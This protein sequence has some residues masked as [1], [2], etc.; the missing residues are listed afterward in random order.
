M[1]PA[2][3]VEVLDALRNSA[4]Y[5]E[6]QNSYILYPNKQLPGFLEKNNVP[7][8]SVR[9]SRLLQKMIDDENSQ[10][11]VKDVDGGY[12]FNGSFRNVN[13]L[14]AGL[15]A[16]DATE[17]AS[18]AQ[19]EEKLIA[20]IFEEV[21]NHKAFTGRSGTFFAYEG[22]GSI[23]WHMV[24]KLHLAVYEICETAYR[25]D[26]DLQVRDAL[27]R[28]FDEIGKGIG[29]HKDP[30]LY[31][32]FPTDPYSH[33][34][35]HRGAQQ[36]GMTGQVKEDVLVR[37][38]ELGIYI[39]QGRLRFDPFLLKKSEFIEEATTFEYSTLDK[40]LAEM[41][42]TPNSIGFT[43]CQVPVKYSIREEESLK[44]EFE[45]GTTLKIKGRELDEDNSRE[46]FHR[47]GKVK[48]ISVSLLPSQLRE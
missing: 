20:T 31:G 9:K 32:A 17:Y 22:L 47:T 6:D 7:E 19:Q 46:V 39:D 18:L 41:E 26:A 11:I 16:L 38:G 40:V 44:L 29:L 27:A 15:E 43:C 36:P 42:L 23:Y 30:E 3:A 25:A 14:K 1:S 37:F 24:S 34:P 10:I 13:D 5:R 35:W 48:S 45:D 33:T 2:D 28:H 12:H 21:F 8:D 4:L